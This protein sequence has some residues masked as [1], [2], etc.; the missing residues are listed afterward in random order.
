MMIIGGGVMGSSNNLQTGID[1]SPFW[2]EVNQILAIGTS[3]MLLNARDRSGLIDAYDGMDHALGEVVQR[4]DP[5]LTTREL[6]LRK[7]EDRIIIF[8]KLLKEEGID[9][10]RYFE[11]DMKKTAVM[12]LKALGKTARK[13]F[14]IDR[15][16]DEATEALCEGN[17]SPDGAKRLLAEIAVG[18]CKGLRN[19]L[20]NLPD[21]PSSI[22]FLKLVS[23]KGTPKAKALA[24]NTL[25]LMMP[26]AKPLRPVRPEIEAVAKVIPIRP[27]RQTL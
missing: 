11:A 4:L 1:E 21:T 22:G 17:F 19:V 10:S 5:S 24:L 3:Q 2:Q 6:L 26:E 18:G 25:N 14:D 23:E 27:L 8:E 7:L 13:D 15:L 20:M 12:V 9:A 16:V